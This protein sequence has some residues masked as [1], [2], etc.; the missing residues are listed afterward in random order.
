MFTTGV[1][2][3]VLSGILVCSLLM[4]AASMALARKLLKMSE[5]Y[6]PFLRHELSDKT[7]EMKKRLEFLKSTSTTG[8]KAA[9]LI[10]MALAV[11]FFYFQ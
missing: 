7:A 5:N 1:V 2:F 11:G 9:A 6:D 3:T 4:R 8:A 10:F